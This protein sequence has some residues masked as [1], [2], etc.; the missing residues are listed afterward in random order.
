MIGKGNDASILAALDV[1]GEY[2]ALGLRLVG[3]P[4]ADGRQEC[5]SASRDEQRPSAYIDTNT[6]KYGDSA[7]DHRE[8]NLWEFAARFG[9]GVA[10]ADWKAAK[11]HYAR[12]AGVELDG[13]RKKKQD[14]REGLEFLEWDAG[15]LLLAEMW[16]A[17]H[18]PGATVE[19][20]RLAGGRVAHWP[21]Y[22]DK[23][24]GEKRRGRFKVLALPAYGPKLLAADPV[25]WVLWNLTGKELEIYQGED[26]PASV[27]KMVSCGPTSGT[28]MNLQALYLLSDPDKKAA[29]EL[30]WKTAGP[31]DMLT[32]LAAIP[33]ELRERHLVVTN[34]SGEPASVHDCIAGAFAGRVAYVVHDADNAGEVGAAKWMKALRGVAVESRHVRLPYPLVTSHGMD[35]R[36]WL[37]SDSRKYADLLS[38]ADDPQ[39]RTYDFGPIDQKTAEEAK[40]TVARVSE[41]S[42]A[43]EVESGENDGGL[44]WSPLSM[45]RVLEK[46]ENAAGG[47]PRRVDSALFVPN[48]TSGVCWLVDPPSTFGWLGNL[49]GVI[50]WHNT[51]GCVTKS[52]V[53]AELKRTSRAY[54]SI[55]I[56]PHCPPLL[57]AFY[58]CEECPPGDGSALRSFLDFFAPATTIDR[59]LMLA[60]VVTMVWGGLPGM[61]PAFVITADAGRGKGKTAFAKL[62]AQIVGGAISFSANEDMGQI[63]TRLLSPNALALRIALLDNVKSHRFSWAELE[64]LITASTISGKRLFVGEGRRPNLLTWVITLN[65][66][67]LSTDMAQRCVI[68]K[69]GEPARTGKWE[70]DATRFVEE[71][72]LRIIADC[73]AF[74]QSDV[75]AELPSYSRWA[76]WEAAILSRL[77]EPFDAQKVILERQAA[78]DVEAEEACL[79]ADDFAHQLEQLNYNTETERI[80]I[81]SSVVADW[82]AKATG[83][84]RTVTSATRAIK[85]LIGEGRLPTMSEN[86]SKALGRGFVWTGFNADVSS[87]IEKTLTYRLATKAT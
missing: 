23:Q 73:I 19:A 13:R 55:E 80:F 16:C 54:D 48:D 86:M 4:R 84:R 87:K 59:D 81:P 20:I 17:R 53:F 22:R 77:P 2:A 83:D 18:K 46:I 12:I 28:L 45:D 74:L 31:S 50:Q 67:S 44:K 21:C 61:R 8:M 9:R 29:V 76:M 38:L 82:F 6:G 27:A 75:S 85:Q 1:A 33:A 70:E 7:A 65:G 10:F 39:N 35:L 3:H 78:T 62:C 36:D 52:E 25:A 57:N 69:V 14:W 5:F 63:Q 11:A 34:A 66:A 43:V 68:I 37:T 64:A 79:L 32:L 71:N 15:E 26:K 40:D 42:N 24:S 30:V 47:W 56:L 51:M 58:T 60:M 49:T 41:V 72:R